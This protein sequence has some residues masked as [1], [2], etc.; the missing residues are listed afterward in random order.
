MA[1]YENNFFTFAKSGV[2]V[3]S[4]CCSVMNYNDSNAKKITK[5]IAK[6]VIR[7]SIISTLTCK[8]F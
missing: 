1:L 7:F 4:K 2:V 6:N 3:D 8:V 5:D